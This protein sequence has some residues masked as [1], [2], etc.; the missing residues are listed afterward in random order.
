M[1]L[2]GGVSLVVATTVPEPEKTV[3]DR[4]LS[5]EVLKVLIVPGHDDEFP[6]AKFKKEREADMA[7]SVAKQLANF[8]GQ[9]P[10]L[11]VVV[12]R[13]NEGYIPS[14]HDY[15]ESQTQEVNDFIKNHSLEM[16][17]EIASGKIVIPKQ[18]P[19]GNAS[20]IPLY[21]LYAINKWATE[22]SFD[23]IIHIHFNDEGSRSLTAPGKFSGYSVYVPDSNLLDAPVSKELGTAIAK[24]LKRDFDPSD[25]SYE[26]NRS[27]KYGVV[28]DI[29]LI[30]LGANKTIA[31]P[32]VLIEYA[33][34]Y[35]PLVSPK[36]FPLTSDVMA[37]ATEY[38]VH[39][40]LKGFE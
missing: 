27:D 40:F 4:Y 26:H 3:S 7:L 17:K 38:G 12:A 37:A 23:L 13:N 2:V 39:D 5:G 8:L 20:K 35:E 28:S 22:Q 21:R 32:R 15:F 14:L 1:F 11:I 18:V 29:K 25:M 10:Q 9:D 24:H 36:N 34:I 16:K 33:Y 6:G 19:H 31:I 30:A